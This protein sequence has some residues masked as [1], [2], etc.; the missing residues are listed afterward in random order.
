MFPSEHNGIQNDIY[1]LWP[2]LAIARQSMPQP[3][4]LVVVAHRFFVPASSFSPTIQVD[5]AGDLMHDHGYLVLVQRRIGHFQLLGNCANNA[6]RDA[7]L[8]SNLTLSSLPNHRIKRVEIC[9]NALI[10]SH[11]RMMPPS[12]EICRNALIIS[13]S[14]VTRDDGIWFGRRACRIRHLLGNHMSE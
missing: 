2:E 4:T 9:R 3:G 6:K 8:S 1:L 12:V 10:T 7:A 14:T 13:H 5:R 11:R